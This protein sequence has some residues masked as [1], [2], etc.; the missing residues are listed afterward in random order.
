M[1]AQEAVAAPSTVVETGAPTGRN[2]ERMAA[3]GAAQMS[4]EAPP[5][6]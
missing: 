1:A 6:V 2:N 3:P 5:A 4:V